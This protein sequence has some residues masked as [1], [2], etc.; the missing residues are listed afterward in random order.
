MGKLRLEVLY[1]DSFQEPQQLKQAVK[2]LSNDVL[3]CI[4][5]KSVSQNLKVSSLVESMD[6]IDLL[7]SGLRFNRGVPF[8]GLQL[9]S[10]NWLLLNPDP[11][12]PSNSW[13]ATSDF[14]VFEANLLDSIGGFDA[15]YTGMDAMIMD[16]AYRVMRAGGLTKYDPN[17][18]TSSEES[19]DH[20]LVED[21]VRFVRKHFNTPALRFYQLGMFLLN[22]KLVKSER[23]SLPQTAIKHNDFRW[24]AKSPLGRHYHPY[25]A[26]I[27]TIDR[28]DYI[29][30]SINSLLALKECPDEIIIVDQTPVTRRRP[31]IYRKYIEKGLVRVEYLERPGQS[32]ARNHAVTLARNEW[33]LLF[34]DDAEAWPDLVRQHWWL[35]DHTQAS[36]SSGVIV[37]PGSKEDFILPANRK[38]FISDIFTTGNAFMQKATILSIGGF[39]PAF[40]SGSGADD[41]FGKRLF[42]AG[43]LIG[44]N[45]KSIETHYKAP[46]GGMRTHSA[47]WRNKS[48]LFGAFP[49]ATQLYA[50]T[51]YYE[52]RYRILLIIAMTLKARNRYSLLGY[53][54]F[55]LLFPI[56]LV[57]SIVECNELVG[58]KNFR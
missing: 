56:K 54:L 28:Y 27:P 1:K 57:R 51:K 45:F 39:D 38:Y 44:Y 42:L 9:C 35:L 13:K 29:E 10:F 36:A 15:S 8:T 58:G 55:L 17:F 12:I 37:P 20:L 19:S 30:L 41:D 49:P 22:R 32:T 48:T 40:D 5:S 34:E 47:L 7:H 31:E 21:E 25:T 50:I 11:A 18:I 52:R 14:V 46:K 33:I 4:C 6:Q 24:I 53:I 43:H 3:V 26:I 16:F 2:S 23:L